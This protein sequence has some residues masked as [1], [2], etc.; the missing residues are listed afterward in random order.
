M[1][2]NQLYSTGLTTKSELDLGLLFY[3]PDYP[4]AI[5]FW[6]GTWDWDYED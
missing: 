3:L 4:S 5:P 2:T 1:L 6:L